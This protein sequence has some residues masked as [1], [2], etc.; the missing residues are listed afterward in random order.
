MT[1]QW[2]KS[3]YALYLKGKDGQTQE[4]P[5]R[6][7]TT[8]SKQPWDITHPISINDKSSFMFFG[9]FQHEN[10]CL[11]PA[12]YNYVRHGANHSHLLSSLKYALRLCPFKLG[13]LWLPFT[14]VLTSFP[15]L[16]SFLFWAGGYLLVWRCEVCHGL[17]SIY[18]LVCLL[19]SAL[20][21]YLLNSSSFFHVCISWAR[22]G[23]P[24]RREGGR[25]ATNH[26]FLIL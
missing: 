16:V 10:S 24:R 11:R 21:V 6:S 18:V 1:R 25:N 2:A 8:S 23:V 19:F 13:V 3:Y 5:S 17:D 22:S 7:K 15:L 12:S 4:K 20:S 9:I 14:P 26:Y